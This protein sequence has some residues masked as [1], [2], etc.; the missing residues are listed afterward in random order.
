LGYETKGSL[1]VLVDQIGQDNV[2]FKA[3]AGKLSGFFSLLL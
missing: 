3:I 1:K 2:P